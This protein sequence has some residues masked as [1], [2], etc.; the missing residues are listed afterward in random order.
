[1]EL[2]EVIG[3]V[4]GC[5]WGWSDNRGYKGLYKWCLCEGRD[6]VIVVVVWLG[7][8]QWNLGA[9][10]S[11]TMCGVGEGKIW[12]EKWMLKMLFS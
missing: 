10:G 11:D 2:R 6:I 3:A 9:V 4:S 8:W 5:Q 12:N 7:R 1:M